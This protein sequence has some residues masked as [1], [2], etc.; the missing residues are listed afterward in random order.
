M[1][2]STADKGTPLF[3]THAILAENPEDDFRLHHVYWFVQPSYEDAKRAEGLVDVTRVEVSSCK[4]MVGQGRDMVLEEALAKIEELEKALLGTGGKLLEPDD[5]FHYEKMGSDYKNAHHFR[6]YEEIR[7]QH[8][9][10]ISA[11]STKLDNG[12]TPMKK[13]QFKSK[14]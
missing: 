5:H 9:A 3:R 13:I 1:I 10:Q 2:F 8:I 14:E 7:Q 6:K 4:I 12:I 11:D